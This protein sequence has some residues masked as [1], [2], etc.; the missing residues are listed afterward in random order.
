MLFRSDDLVTQGIT[1][2]YRM[3]TSRAEFRLS[4]RADNADRRLTPLGI[5]LGLVGDRRRRVFEDKLARLDRLTTEAKRLAVTPSEAE[6]FGLVVNKDGQ[7]RSAF[8]LL[9]R[10]ELSFAD[11]ERIWPELA[12]HG[13]DVKEQVEID[14]T[15]AVYL[16]RQAAEVAAVDRD[17]GLVI[18]DDFRF[19]DIPGLSN[20]LRHKLS[21]VRPG[22]LGQ[23]GRIDG[24]TPAALALLLGR[25]RR[26]QS[27]TRDE[28]LDRAIGGFDS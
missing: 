15:Y 26:S 12:A 27:A 19:D 5:E 13:A 16:D 14:A 8:E 21:V 22:T 25:I 9:S 24:M 4:L 6:R 3:F 1:E 11:V 17:E 2:P 28:A 10:P 20:E 7:R 23:A 18:P